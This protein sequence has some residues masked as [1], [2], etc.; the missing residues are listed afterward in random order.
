MLRLQILHANTNIH[1]C[2]D[3]VENS[4]YL[5]VKFVDIYTF[6]LC[7]DSFLFSVTLSK[8]TL[9]WLSWASYQIRKTAGCACVGIAENIIPHRLQRRSLV[10]DPG[11]HHGTCVTHVPWCMP[12]SQTRGGGVVC[13]LG[14]PVHYTLYTESAVEEQAREPGPRLNIKTVFPRYG[15]LMLKIRRSLDH[16][17]LNM[18]IPILVGRHFHTETAV[19]LP[20][21]VRLHV[22][23]QWW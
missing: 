10:S 15:I 19:I 13:F 16:L 3:Y 17:I 23:E 4:F 11:L 20:C 1:I 14:V 18:G 8:I 22:C 2:E 9:P 21:N 6:R 12:G 7:F 5:G